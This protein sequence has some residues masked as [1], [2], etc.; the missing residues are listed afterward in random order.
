VDDRPAEPPEDEQPTS[1]S[2]AGEN[3][4]TAGV[5]E[6]DVPGEATSGTAAPRDT[7]AEDE[8]ARTGPKTFISGSINPNA[9]KFERAPTIVIRRKRKGDHGAAHGG[10]GR[11]RMPISSPR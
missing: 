5:A 2:P 4:P 8:A 3:A 7:D 6:T 1:I 11:L 9:T 10:R